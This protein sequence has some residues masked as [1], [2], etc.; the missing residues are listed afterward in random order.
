MFYVVH[1]L[2]NDVFLEN[3][4][5]RIIHI[6]ILLRSIYAFT[7]NVQNNFRPPQNS[8]RIIV[9]TPGAHSQRFGLEY[10]SIVTGWVLQT[11]DFG[12][13]QRKQ[14]VGDKSDDRCV[15][16]VET[17]LQ[18]HSGL[19]NYHPANHIHQFNYLSTK[20]STVVL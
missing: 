17:P 13:P 8:G 16:Y 18:V 9:R 12:W 2:F 20:L 6:C 11:T 1:F 5:H 3:H 15:Y 4:Y 10:F 14:S 19:G 7:T